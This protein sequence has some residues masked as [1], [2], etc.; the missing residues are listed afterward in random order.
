MSDIN[1][2]SSTYRSDEKL[3]AI[4]EETGEWAVHVRGGGI[5]CFASSLR[6]ALDK[7]AANASSGTTV[8]VLTRNPSEDIVVHSAQMVRMQ[9][10]VSLKL[11][12]PCSGNG[13]RPPYGKGEPVPFVPA[14]TSVAP[15]APISGAHLHVPG[16]GN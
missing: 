14:F 12:R 3:D 15:T 4:L 5:L 8:E 2:Y 6:D 13:L 7:S 1:L 16:P 9:S 11:S 10:I